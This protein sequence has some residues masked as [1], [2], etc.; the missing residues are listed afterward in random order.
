MIEFSVL[1]SLNSITLPY[2][3]CPDA[4]F[5]VELRDSFCNFSSDTH[6]IEIN[7]F[8]PINLTCPSDTIWCR[9]GDSTYVELLVID[10]LGFYSDEHFSMVEVGSSP[11]LS[12]DVDDSIL[13]F[14]D[15]ADFYEITL[16]V[17]D[18]LGLADTCEFTICFSS[19]FQDISKGW[20]LLSVPTIEPVEYEI[21]YPHAVPPLWEYNVSRLMYEEIDNV[22]CGLG[23]WLFSL[24]D[25]FTSFEA[26]DLCTSTE[27]YLYNGWNLIG[28]PNTSVP[29]SSMTIYPEIV[30]PIYYF[31]VST[32][33]YI[34]VDTLERFKGYWILS[35]DS[36]L[37]SFP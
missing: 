9:F 30:F 36:L 34:E 28:I 26:T 27:S 18:Y 29:V 19:E 21:F 10:E 24:N 13:F 35:T 8:P 16:T 14:A 2:V 33:S 22:F 17:Y 23:F 31:N 5:I 32:G 3:D 20:N 6:F 4:Y 37:I 7:N 15:E 25:T 11:D 12:I 1:D